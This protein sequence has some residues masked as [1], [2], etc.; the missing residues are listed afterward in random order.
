MT[1]QTRNAQ[2]ERKDNE[3]AGVRLYRAV[4]RANSRYVQDRSQENQKLLAEA[5]AT[6]HNHYARNKK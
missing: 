1:I 6:Y 4:I 2:R 5:W 3:D